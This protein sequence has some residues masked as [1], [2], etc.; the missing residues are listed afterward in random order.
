M[1]CCIVQR[2]Q[3][4]EVVEIWH[5]GLSKQWSWS[6]CRSKMHVGGN[7]QVKHLPSLCFIFSQL[8]ALSLGSFYL[9]PQKQNTFTLVVA[10][11]D[12]AGMTTNAFTSSTDVIINVKES[13]WKA[14][15]TIYIQENSTETHPV[16]ISQVGPL[17]TVPAMLLSATELF[18]LISWHSTMDSPEGLWHLP[19]IFHMVSFVNDL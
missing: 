18:S 16:N 13:L 15:P 11:K 14:P 7:G 12:M 3:K 4:K 6:R 5:R 1:L 9:D 19:V 8:F 2:S 17:A 10:V